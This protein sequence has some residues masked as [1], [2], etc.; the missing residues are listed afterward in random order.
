MLTKLILVF[1]I[2]PVKAFQSG[3]VEI[4]HNN[5]EYSQWVNLK[6]LKTF[7]PLPFDLRDPIDSYFNSSIYVNVFFRD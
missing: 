6:N 4:I 2:Y 3:P 5:T 7:I 1:L